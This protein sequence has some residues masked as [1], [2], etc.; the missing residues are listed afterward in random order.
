MSEPVNGNVTLVFYLLLSVTICEPNTNCPTRL[1]THARPRGDAR[2]SPRVC[3]VRLCSVT[4]HSRTRAAPIHT[5]APRVGRVRTERLHSKQTATGV[6]STY[7]RHTP[8]RPPSSHA[9]SGIRQ[10]QGSSRLHVT[11]RTPVHAPRAWAARPLWPAGRS[12]EARRHANYVRHVVPRGPLGSGTQRYP[13][14]HP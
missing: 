3:S 14:T 2:V 4:E 6:F 7:L 9:G 1:D 13:L 10:G 12:P 11:A 5:N 8:T